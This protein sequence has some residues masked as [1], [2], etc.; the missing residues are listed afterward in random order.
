MAK[1]LNDILKVAH[2]RIRGVHSST[3]SDLSTGKDPGVDYAPPAS[4]DRDFI[5]KHSV[6]KWDEPEGNPNYADKVKD[7]PHPK[8]SKSVY[9]SKKAEDTKCNKT[10]GQTWCPLHEMADCSKSTTIKEKDEGKPGLNFKKIANKAAKEYGSKEAG[11]RVAGAIRAKIL[12]KE[13]SI[14]EDSEYGMAR[15]ELATASRAIDRLNAKMGKGEGELEAWVQAKITKASDYLDTVADYMESGTIK[16]AYDDNSTKVSDWSDKKLKWHASDD[17]K[18]SSSHVPAWSELRRRA[19]TSAPAPKKTNEEAEQVDEVSSAL[20]HRAFQKAKKNAGW[21]M[22][23]DGGKGDK[24]WNRVKKFRDAGVAK[25]KQEKAVKE[26]AVNEISDKLA[27]SYAK[28]ASKSMDTAAAKG[29]AGHETFMKR[30]AGHALALDKTNPEHKRLK[31]KVGTSDA[32]AK[33]AAYK[34]A[35]GEAI[36]PG[37]FVEPSDSAKSKAKQIQQKD[38]DNAALSR[39]KMG[40][41]EKMDDTQKA[42]VRAAQNWR[43][44][45]GT[46]KPSISDTKRTIGFI[47]KNSVAKEETDPGFEEGHVPD[48]QPK[49]APKDA[50]TMSKVAA[51]M[52]KERES[53]RQRQAG[54]TA[55]LVAANKSGKDS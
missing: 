53:F 17:R 10:P 35:I 9:E 29:S 5:A 22:P 48:H 24:A 41:T 7:A 26:E 36:L 12:A 14:K 16:E 45:T 11:N 43:Q 3:T 20:L 2:D 38:A 8:Q 50:S 51:M 27:L 39:A 4:N 37:T 34:K 21:L 19:K 23:G 33:D 40:I 18:H 44:K 31:A 30:S 52:A 32:N 42:A 47:K 15:N 6:Q 28:G 46:A 1:S 13:E 55:K 25:E 54:N 49:L